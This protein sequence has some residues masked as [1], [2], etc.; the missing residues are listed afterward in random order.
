MYYRVRD[1]S[2]SLP[3]I[4]YLKVFVGRFD[5]KTRYALDNRSEEVAQYYTTV[6]LK[7]RG[8][9]ACAAEMSCIYI[10]IQIKLAVGRWMSCKLKV[11][12]IQVAGR[13]TELMIELVLT[14]ET[15]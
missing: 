2:D 5:G 12:T 10:H 1:L 14:V 4:Y 15:S 3:T 6:Q 9:P 11:A 8:E 13:G 7:T